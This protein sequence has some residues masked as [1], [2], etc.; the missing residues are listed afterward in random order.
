MKESAIIAWTSMYIAVGSMALIC[1]VLAVVVT[2]SDWYTRTWRPALSRKL[3][4]VLLVPKIWLRW[5]INYLKGAPVIL[6]VA[7][8]YASDVGFYVFWDI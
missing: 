8:Y 7:L 2:G 6:A 4:F 3:D 5:Q 1:A